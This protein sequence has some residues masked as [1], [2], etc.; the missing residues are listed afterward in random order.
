MSDRP[1]ALGDPRIAE[2]VAPVQFHSATYRL[3]RIDGLESA[4]EDYGQAVGY[5]G[6]VPDAPHRFVLDKHHNMETGRLFPVCGN[7]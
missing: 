5:L 1:L 3:F 4:C 2:A 6:T 7:T